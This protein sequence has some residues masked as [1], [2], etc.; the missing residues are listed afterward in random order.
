MED[1]EGRMR[2][3][4]DERKGDREER[5]GEEEERRKRKKLGDMTNTLTHRQ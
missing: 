5:G 3:R 4:W 2:E 1:R